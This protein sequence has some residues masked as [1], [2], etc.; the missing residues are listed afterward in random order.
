MEVQVRELLSKAAYYGITRKAIVE[1][2]G[3]AITSFT[4]WRNKSPRISTFNRASAAL[5]QLIAE[6]AYNEK[7]ESQ[8]GVLR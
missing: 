1:K 3:I 2:A 8:K 7:M 4:N 6:R 5:D